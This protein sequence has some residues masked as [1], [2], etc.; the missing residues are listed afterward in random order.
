MNILEYFR[1]RFPNHDLD[2]DAGA[3]DGC[4]NGDVLAEMTLESPC[5]LECQ[6]AIDSA[7]LMGASIHK[8][9]GLEG[10]MHPTGRMIFPQVVNAAVE[11]CV[12]FI[13]G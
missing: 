6:I 11:C 13:R 3:G 7:V 5:G 8:A 12:C 2:D 10:S 4:T 1:Q 9:Y